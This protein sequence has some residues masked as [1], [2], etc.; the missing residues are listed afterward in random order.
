MENTNQNQIE[1]DDEVL[2]EE[3]EEVQESVPEEPRQMKLPK[4]TADAIAEFV[5][6][7]DQIKNAKEELKIPI[8]RKSELEGSIRQFMEKE[9]IE[10]L[11]LPNATITRFKTKKVE[12]FKKENFRGLVESKISNKQ[13]VEEIMEEFT[14]RPVTYVEK[15]KVKSKR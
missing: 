13:I 11:R 12:A 7:Q 2:Q 5:D 1:Q 10:E 15:I 4:E 14:N 8:D 3:H 6:L 9:D